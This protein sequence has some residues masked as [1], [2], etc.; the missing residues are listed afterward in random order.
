MTRE[1]NSMRVSAALALLLAA[2]AAPQAAA[3]EQVGVVEKERGAVESFFYSVWSTVRS[4][5]PTGRES[6]T[7]EGVT[8]TAG[9]RGAEGESEAM[10]PYWKGDLTDDPAFR[11]EVQAYQKALEKGRDGQPQALEQFLSKHGDGEL[12]ANARFA[13]GVAYAQAGNT[14]D[15]REA[16]G[17]FRE[18]YAEHPL[19]DEAQRVLERLEG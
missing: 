8:V 4:M 10:A 18:R 3:D 15:A 9:L 1:R 11:N 16:L 5:S 13:L 12:A 2:V 17:T 14:A 7:P 6:R 19:S